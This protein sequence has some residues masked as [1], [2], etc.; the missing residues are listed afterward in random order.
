MVSIVT[1][2]KSLMKQNNTLTKVNY[3]LI[4]ENKTVA[5]EYKSRIIK[6]RKVYKKEIWSKVRN[7]SKQKDKIF[8]HLRKEIKIRTKVIN[9]ILELLVSNEEKLHIEIELS[10]KKLEL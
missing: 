2:T 7:I 3:K 5:S 9:K 10:K 4:D 8:K 1:E 6:Q